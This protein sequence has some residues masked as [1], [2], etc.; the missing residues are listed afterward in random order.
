VTREPLVV[1]VS[2]PIR[3]GKTTL[4]EN[5]VD[6]TPAALLRTRDVLLERAGGSASRQQ[7][8]EL[9]RTLD[10]ATGGT[11]VLR[12]VESLCDRSEASLAVVDATRIALQIECLRSRFPTVHVH[13]TAPLS[14]LRDRWDSQGGQLPYDELRAD[15][16]EAQVE[17]LTSI[18]DLVIDTS[19][20][21]PEETT[22]AVLTL[23][24]RS[25]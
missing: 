17:S 4:A 22:R 13:L 6:A 1:A 14:V 16:T 2:G 3:A 12:A 7:L 18:A 5:L 15:P 10:E 20:R 21:N 24:D 23:L 8:Q 11:W 9:G 25:R 19:T